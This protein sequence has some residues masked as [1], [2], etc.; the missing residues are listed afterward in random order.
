MF[1]NRNVGALKNKDLSTVKRSEEP[2]K[3]KAKKM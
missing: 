2:V 3:N 1:K